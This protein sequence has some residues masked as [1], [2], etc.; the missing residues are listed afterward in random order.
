MSRAAPR[1]TCLLTS[2]AYL[3]E[4]VAG[5]VGVLV[6][7]RDGRID[8]ILE[9]PDLATLPDGTEVVDLQPWS[10]APGF[11]DLHTHGFKGFDVTTGSLADIA[12]MARALPT[13]GVT[14]FYPTI[15]STGPAETRTQITR[16]SQAASQPDLV[17]AEILGI[18]LEG[19]YINLDKR[20]AQYAPAI[21]PPDP[22]ELTALAAEGPVKMVDFAPE[23]DV[24]FRLLHQMLRL[25]I[26]PSLGHTAA[27]YTQAVEA[28]EAGARHCAHLF[29]AMPPVDHRAPGAVGALLTDP[30]ASVE[31]IADG[32]HVHP[33]VLRLAVAARGPQHV[34]LVTDA[35][36]AAGRSDGRYTFLEREIVVADGAVRLNDGTLAGSILTLDRA[37]RNMVALAGLTWAEA[38]RMA[39]LTPAIVAGLATRKGRLRAGADAD[40]VVLD[41]GGTLRQTWIH[42]RPVFA[43]ASGEG[44]PACRHN[45]LS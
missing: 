8:A 31:I 1:I 20:G 29:N 21:R 19:P 2:R 35:M 28:I 11:I 4:E 42:G 30:R 14:A 41:E 16:I 23:E 3:P 27:T 13:T 36:H 12:A 32:V 15:A 5:P 39:S 17:S 38:L 18:R 25:G 10:V 40:L 37:V 9:R 43:A 6:D 22:A 44:V 45:M 34:A 7:G 33:A 26:V 24:G